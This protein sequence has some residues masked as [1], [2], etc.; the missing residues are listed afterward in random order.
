MSGTLEALAERFTALLGADDVITDPVRLRTYECDGLTYHKAT[1]GLVVLPQSAAQ[2]AAVVRACAAE[3]VPYV[4][5]GSGTGL[6]GGALPRTDG[7]LIVT[8]KMRRIIEVD[9]ANQRA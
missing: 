8:S 6:S 7:V 1:P 2:I 4:A 9:A 5:R 3:G